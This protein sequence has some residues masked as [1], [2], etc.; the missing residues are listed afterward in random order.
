[1]RNTDFVST[2]FDGPD[3]PNKAA[4]AFTMSLAALKKGHSC[5]VI[6]MGD[7]SHYAKAGGADGIHIGEPFAALA[8]LMQEFIE[9]GGQIVGCKSCIIHQGI[10][11]DD[12]QPEYEVIT[13]PDVVDL[14]MASKGSLQL[15]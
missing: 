4:I 7:A 15:T 9:L 1:M 5:T 8:T 2:V 12:V 6:L 13:A 3:K 14:L 10:Q 11:L